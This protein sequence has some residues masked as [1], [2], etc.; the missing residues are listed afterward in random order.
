VNRDGTFDLLYDDG[1]KDL[2][3]LA[4]NMRR[5][6]SERDSLRES[7]GRT[8]PRD[9]VRHSRDLVDYREGDKV[10]AL[11]RGKGT[12]YYS[13][14]VTKVNRDGTCDLLF[15]DGD[16]NLG[17]LASHMRMIGGAKDDDLRK[18]PTRDLGRSRDEGPDYREGDKIEGLY[19]GKGSKWYKGQVARVN[20]DG[21]FDLLYDDGDKDLG[22]LASNMRLPF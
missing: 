11:Y 4:S 6:G 16:T 8:P 19:R 9:E 14:V 15:D 7:R 1:D 22:A 10:E 2:G 21:T 18:S 12:R 5:L 20:R 17:A 3:A 13:G